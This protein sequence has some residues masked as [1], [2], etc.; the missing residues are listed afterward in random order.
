V[1]LIEK[2]GDPDF[3]KVLDFGIAKVPIGE[4]SSKQQG[5][6]TKVGMVFGTPEYMAP[7]QALGQPVDG[8]ADLYALGVMLYELLAGVRPFS[9][10]SPVGILGQQLSKPPPTFHDRV[11]GLVVPPQVEALTFKLLAKEHGDRFGSA[12]DVAKAIE[13][14]LAPGAG[15]GEH[16]FTLA[17][18]SP[19]SVPELRIADSRESL[20]S[21]PGLESIPDFSVESTGSHPALLTARAT[22]QPDGALVV[23]K[24]A[25]ESALASV[26]AL[27]G[28]AY[29]SIDE[30]R[31]MLPAPAREALR[32]V[33]AAVFFW[34][35][36]VTLLGGLLGLLLLVISLA[37]SKPAP[38]LALGSAEPA[39]SAKPPAP[40]T[41]ERSSAVSKPSLMDEIAGAKARGSDGLLELA[42]SHPEDPEVQ[43]E[44]VRALSEEKKHTDAVARVDKLLTDRPNGAADDRVDAAL[45]AAA[46]SRAAADA[47][48]ALLEGKLGTR[49][50]DLLFQ[51]ATDPGVKL[52][53]RMRAERVMRSKRFEQ[54]ASPALYAAFRL[55]AAGSCQQ[56]YGTLLLAKNNGDE[57]ALKILKSWEPTI[58]CSDRKRECNACLG[59]DDRFK[60][61]MDAIESRVRN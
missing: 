48:F 44:L 60:Q 32:D 8:R 2:G 23:A 46:Q 57:R 36:L 37:A 1:M 41:P 55:L 12:D 13:A 4:S 29:T 59:A 45:I 9:S 61:A 27:L 20:L 18:G 40:S 16:R 19:A 43:L 38:P 49:G 50:A 52:E 15:R 30:R 5:P 58:D 10:Q 26:T 42:K 7:E 54:L 56:R 39:A 47:S 24:Q 53:A 28:R 14:L 6:I 3:V 34:G 11:P 22:A 33:P 17:G 35:L 21:V 25:V 31:G 51:L